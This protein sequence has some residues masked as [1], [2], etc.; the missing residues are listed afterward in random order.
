MKQMNEQNLNE[1]Q[2][3][4]IKNNEFQ[5][6]KK[7]ALCIVA[8]A[9]SGKTTTIINKVIYMIKY[10]NCSPCDFVLTTFTKNATEEIK[11]RIST[12]LPSDIVE[13][14]TIG[15]FHAIALHEITDHS[16]KTD[17]NMPESMPEEYLINYIELLNDES[18]VSKFKYIFID[19][20]QDINHFQYEIIRKWYLSSTHAKLLTVVG[21]DQ[22]NI[23]TFRNTSIKYILNFC[24]DFNGSYKYLTTNYRCNKGI[25][26]MTNAIISFN[27]DKIEKTILSGSIDD[28]TTYPKIRFFK[29]D[30]KEKE[31][32]NEYIKKIFINELTDQSADQSADQSVDQSADQSVDQFPTIA[33]LS[34]TNKKLYKVENFLALNNVKTQMLNAE[35]KEEQDVEYDSIILS[36]IHSSKG[37]EFDYVI[38][39]NCVDGSFPII[40]ANIEEE[41]RLFYVACTRAKKKLLITSLLFDKYKPS[42]FIYE[43][44]KFYPNLINTIPFEWNENEYPNLMNKR[45][46]KLSDVLNNMDINIYIELKQKKVLPSD[47]YMNFTVIQV[48]QFID[49]LKI[50]NYSNLTD[51]EIIFNNMINLHTDRIIQEIIG[52]DDYIYLPYIKN[53]QIFKNCRYTLIKA[54]IDYLADNS[55]TTAINKHTDYLKKKKSEFTWPSDTDTNTKTYNK[56]LQNILNLLLEPDFAT[57]DLSI[58]TK[59]NKLILADSYKK[60]QNQTY[61]SV[62]IIDDIANLSVVNELNKGRY[63]LQLLLDKIEFINK[64]DLIEHIMVINEWFHSNISLAEYV[65]WDHDI[66]INKFSVGKINLIIDNRMIII[67]AQST[68]KPSINEFI[69]YI[70]FW[71]KYNMS[72]QHQNKLKIIQCYNPISG[73]IFEWDLSDWILQDNKQIEQFLNYF[74]N[75]YNREE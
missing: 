52:V 53:D 5:G 28:K 62:D 43:L 15:T 48:H 66:I 74:I 32:I 13:Q 1:L 47:E 10:L 31:Y 18:Y 22:Q 63:S 9:G 75:F 24:Q 11:K 54:L 30:Q 55:N 36:T 42:R 21:D 46:N 27:T 50:I 72:N 37:L 33:I 71:A 3:D 2:I 51:L 61:R 68:Q 29:N 44:Y 20:Y 60:W 73:K 39:M 70:L 38:I 56:I 34:R 26:E 17:P 8:C 58:L 19:E 45:P 6:S 4:I 59:T 16:Y 49:P 40:G 12:H 65:E 41:R 67:N 14:I 23:Y 7:Q 64:I 69:K 35:M 25:V 57:T